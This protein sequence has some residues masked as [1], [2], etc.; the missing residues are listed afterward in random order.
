M[1]AYFFLTSILMLVFFS[2]C[3]KNDESPGSSMSC[4]LPSSSVPAELVGNWA[5]GY[6]SSTKIVDAYTGE[7]VGNAFQSGK[8]F[9]FEND[10]KNAE[11]YYLANAGVNANT[12][13]K[14]IGT[15]E[16]LDDE[17]FIFHACKAHYKGWQNGALKVDR[18]ATDQEVASPG[19]TQKYYYTMVTSGDITYMQIKFDKADDY[20]TS[21]EK[22]P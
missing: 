22:V 18:D 20:G 4:N 17:S 16:F 11:F 19:L 10:G 2:G 1:K 7:Y 5:N 9:H 6:N 14:A 8:L 12:A 13:T 15:V 21:F 3:K